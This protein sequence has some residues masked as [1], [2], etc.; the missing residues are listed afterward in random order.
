MTITKNEIQNAL[1]Q[2]D[3]AN[4][5]HWTADGSPRI[6]AV[7]AIANDDTI[8]R[9]AINDAHPGF[10]RTS[11]DPVEEITA[12]GGPRVAPTDVS[13]IDDGP[14]PVEGSRYTEEELKAVMLRR[15]RD[16]EEQVVRCQTA[17]REANQDL[18]EAQ[19]R[20]TK[21]RLD[22]NRRFPPLSPAANIKQHLA[23]QA[24][25]AEAE[26]AARGPGSSR[27]QIDIAMERSNS[28]G[29]VRPSRPVQNA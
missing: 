8:T 5:Q 4:E 13:E 1:L 12:V 9:Q 23:A 11:T 15:Y 17:I 20:E 19:R 10:S 27:G 2:L 7:C 25:R 3:P 26:I 16:T 6:T 29:W 21:A 14:D 28:R 18:A 24:K 22:L